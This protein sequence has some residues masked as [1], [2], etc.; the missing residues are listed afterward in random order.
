MILNNPDGTQT[1]FEAVGDRSG[2]PILLLHGIG[3]DHTMW[4]KQVRPYADAGYYLL[5][6]DLF[7]HGCSSKL[8]HIDLSTWHKQLNWLL[9]SQAVSSCYLIGVSMGGVIA[10]SFVTEYQ[11][12]VE[13]MVIS[14]SFGELR[15]VKERLL[16][17]A[18]LIGFYLFKVLG[19]RRLANTMRTAYKAAYAQEARDYFE[20]VSLQVD[21]TQ[22]ILA[23][24]AINQI[25]VLEKLKSV[26][27][28][29]LVIVGA[30]F[31]PAFIDINAKIANALPNAELVILEQAMDPSNL[32][33]PIEFDRRVLQ[34]LDT[35]LS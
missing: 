2:K 31:G 16:G 3:A 10:Q 33:N 11:A 12:K 6:P 24:K 14:D 35:G 34:F 27:T 22:M 5:M 18:Q 30:D 4:H 19:N 32:V 23:R 28:P 9:A 7:G 20:Q 1:Y 29:T 8:E 25:D 26:V 21:L 17:Q 13:K 15:T